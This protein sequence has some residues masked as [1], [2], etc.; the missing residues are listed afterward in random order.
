MP[1][2]H[3]IGEPPKFAYIDA[4]GKRI[5]NKKV[6]EYIGSLVIPPKYADV[7][8][9]VAMRGDDP[10]APVKLTY[11]GIDPAGR[12]QYGYSAAWKARASRAKYKD[13]IA[14]GH[15]LPRIRRR[16][17]SSLAD[18]N[19]SV[20]PAMDTT[21]ALIVRIVSICHFRL[22]HLKYK[23]LYKSYGVSTIEVR[24]LKFSQRPTGGTVA[25]I[26]FVGKKG[27]KNNCL[28]D[29]PDVVHHLANMIAGKQPK[30]HV[31]TYTPADDPS[32]R[33]VIKANDIN[34]WMREFG[35]DISSKMFRT[36]ATNVMMI[37]QL[38][39]MARRKLKMEMPESLTIAQ[40]K[41]NI[42]MAL[43]EVSGTVHNTRAVCKK[44]YTYP[45]LI[46]MYLN[47]PRRYARMFLGDV[48]AEHAF[49]QFLVDDHSAAG[50]DDEPD[51]LPAPWEID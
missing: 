28:I 36:Y 20:A 31:F 12:T 22:G 35:A 10:C 27:V 38:N 26:S 46:D 4:A 15:V 42:N 50:G 23:D 33:A 24:H 43:D 5:T 30:E 17:A 11:T 39:A 1:I 48:E 32:M 2:I 16:V 45:P 7:K 8:I 44:E 40:R 21:I 47:H 19:A 34:L 9:Y 18:P 14:F 41:K 13:L 29:A 49:L 6:L 37:E 3:R 25:K 51:P